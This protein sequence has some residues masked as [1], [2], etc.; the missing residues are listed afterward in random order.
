MLFIIMLFLSYM[1]YCKCEHTKT[2]KEHWITTG[3]KNYYFY[4]IR[5]FGQNSINPCTVIKR[6]T[7]FR[8]NYV[9][10][11]ILCEGIWCI[12][13]AFKCNR[14]KTQT[15]YNVEHIIDT[16]RY[17]ND[18]CTNI[19]ANLVM[20]Y[21]KWNTELG[22]LPYKDSE[23]EKREVY[24]DDIIKKTYEYINK[25]NPMCEN[26]YVDINDKYVDNNNQEND[27]E[28]E[29]D[30]IQKNDTE[31]E[32]YNNQENYIEY[33]NIYRNNNDYK[34]YNKYT[35]NTNFKNNN[36]YVEFTYIFLSFIVMCIFLTFLRTR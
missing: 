36:K 33:V 21:G 7:I 5:T 17:N 28:Y 30:N 19:Y 29:S 15:C 11:N 31:Y 4:D 23:T 35:Y 2:Y 1:Q 12:N 3:N 26:K 9:N 13:K 14:Y 18:N 6:N 25:C 16:R 22:R 10:K 20:A 32:N 27:T 34:Y 24:G 8:D